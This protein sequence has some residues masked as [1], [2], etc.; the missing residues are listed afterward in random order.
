MKLF[1]LLVLITGINMILVHRGKTHCKK[2]CSQ[3]RTTRK[4]MWVAHDDQF[5]S[6]IEESYAKFHVYLAEQHK[7]GAA[8][9]EA[10]HCSC[11]YK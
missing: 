1:C 6:K 10:E 7:Y 5:H 4:S 9:E 2:L 8:L 11:R 3:V